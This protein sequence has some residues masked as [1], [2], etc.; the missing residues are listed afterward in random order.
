MKPDR[1][2]LKG[3]PKF[4]SNPEGKKQTSSGVTFLASSADFTEFDKQI[5]DATVFLKI[6]RNEILSMA[7]HQSVECA[8]LDFGVALRDEMIHCDTINPQFLTAV[9]GLN[10]EVEISHYPCEE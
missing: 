8:T 6:N 10:I 4:K 9:G 7:T 1:V 2:W 5:E 3:E